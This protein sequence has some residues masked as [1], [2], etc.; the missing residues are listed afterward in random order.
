MMNKSISN[1]GVSLSK[2]RTQLD[3]IKFEHVWVFNSGVLENE[4]DEGVFKTYLKY[5]F[6]HGAMLVRNRRRN[7]NRKYFRS[8]D[9]PKVVHGSVKNR[10]T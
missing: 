4:S 2:L 7:K 6:V 8:T 9:F 3:T 5:L 10:V 1:N